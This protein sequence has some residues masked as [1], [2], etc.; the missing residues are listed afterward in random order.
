[1]EE[2]QEEQLISK[3]TSSIIVS[4]NEKRIITNLR[5]L[6][7]SYPNGEYAVLFIN[8]QGQLQHGTACHKDITERI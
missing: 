4:A 8:H 3:G 7:K 1:M 5:R 6:S 2:D